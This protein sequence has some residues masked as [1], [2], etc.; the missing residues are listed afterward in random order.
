MQNAAAKARKSQTWSRPSESAPNWNVRASTAR[1]AIA[2][3][4]RSE[5]TS[6]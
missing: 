1:P 2:A 3:S 6:V 5:P 4:M